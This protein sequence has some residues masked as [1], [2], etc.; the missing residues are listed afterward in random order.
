MVGGMAEEWRGVRRE[1]E[2]DVTTSKVTK[3]SSETQRD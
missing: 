3:K 1:R 2:L